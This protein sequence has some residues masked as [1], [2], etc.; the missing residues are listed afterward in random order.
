M[1]YASLAKVIFYN[2]LIHSL[3]SLLLEEEKP[4]NCWV[5]VTSQ[6]LCYCE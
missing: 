2:S 6:C 4:C 5:F 1:S 3:F